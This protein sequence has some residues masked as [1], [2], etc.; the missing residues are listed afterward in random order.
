MNSALCTTSIVSALLCTLALPSAHAQAA[1][2]MPVAAKGYT[3]SVF[4]RGGQYTA[5]D[6]IAVDRGHIFVGYGDDN[7]PDG[8]DGKSTQ[9]VQYS[10]AGAVEWIYTVKGHNDGLKVDPY[11][12]YLWALQNEDANPNA[13]AINYTTH[14]Q[15]SFTFAAAPPHGGGYDDI[16]F[17][18]GKVY[19]SASNPANNPNTGPA[20]VEAKLAGGTSVSVS[21]VLMGNG[22]ATDI[23]TGQPITL[24]LQDPD[25]MTTDPSGDL[26]M[27]SQADGELVIVRH[28]ETKNQ[29]VL[30]VPL[31]SPFGV[32]M[33]DDTLFTPD[34]D[35]F[36]LVADKP[37]NTIYAIRRTAFAPG[38]AYS[39][40]Q[41]TANGG[42]QGFVGRLD[43]DYGQ[44]TP[45]I[46]GMGSPGGMAFVPYD[47]NNSILEEA[48]DFCYSLESYANNQ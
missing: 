1:A 32:P 10:M 47:A 9:V 46:T 48:L 18:N 30:R 5:P 39:S 20:I 2:T 33:V 16:V 23:L 15:T 37:A 19:L 26:V 27:T 13:V 45:V 28:P 12:H 11:Q 42:T 41:T 14:Q 43:V 25:S 29:S 3:V 22:E 21:A 35:G 40:A 38:T 24:N 8:S 31:S 34:T 6:S 7:L 36:I 44:L 4:A 17:R